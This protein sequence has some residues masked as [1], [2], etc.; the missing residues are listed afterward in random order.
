MLSCS[1]ALVQGYEFIRVRTSKISLS[2]SVI[3][4]SASLPSGYS[5]SFTESSVPR[6]RSSTSFLL[7]YC[8]SRGELAPPKLAVTC[9]SPLETLA[10]V[11]ARG[12]PD[13]F[14]SWTL[15]LRAVDSSDY[16]FTKIL[17]RLA[18]SLF[19]FTISS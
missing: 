16:A 12:R 13:T 1:P 7:D 17:F 9:M 10:M 11:S 15:T 2:S 18:I 6:K 4:V 8:W 3:T 14:D 19:C 5:S